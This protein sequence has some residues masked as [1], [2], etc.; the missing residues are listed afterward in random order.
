MYFIIIYN[1]RHIEI[2]IKL[3]INDS[4]NNSNARLRNVRQ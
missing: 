3:H 1:K 2:D 4:N